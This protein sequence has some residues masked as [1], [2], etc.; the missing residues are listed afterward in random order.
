MSKIV[1]TTVTADD[2][3]TL[4]IGETGDSVNISGD[5]LNVNALQDAGGNAIFTSD[6]SGTVTAG[7]FPGSM[8]LISTQ[9]AS[10]AASVSFTSGLDSTYDVY[11]FKL[12]DINGT[13]DSAEF[14]FQV[15]TNGGSSYGVNITS[16][17]YYAANTEADSG[18]ISYHTSYDL[19]QSTNYQ[20]IGYDLGSD[21]DECLAGNLYLFA[22]SSTTYVKQFASTTTAYDTGGPAGGAQN[23]FV[24]GYVNTTSA[25][26]ALNFKMNSGNFDRIISLYGIS[27]T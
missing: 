25:V 4:T 19:A 2:T 18:H 1:T 21:A 10:G 9:T 20:T 3:N 8:K 24:D 6:G 16:S 15:S 7:S 14:T 23:T 26:D 17:F 11:L 22:P 12:F 13:S 5:S 27:K